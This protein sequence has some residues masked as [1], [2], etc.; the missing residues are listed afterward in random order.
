VRTATTVA[1]ATEEA[2]AVVLVLAAESAGSITRSMLVG[3]AT[4]A[5]RHLSVVHQAGPALAEA[6]ARRP[7]A[8]RRTRLATLLADALA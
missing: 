2:E 6:V 3:A 1:A 4:Q 8:P 5:R 7:H